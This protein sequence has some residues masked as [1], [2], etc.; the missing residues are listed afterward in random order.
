[1]LIIIPVADK[2]AVHGL[3]GLEVNSTSTLD[4]VLY[5]M[6]I[7]VTSTIRNKQISNRVVELVITD[8]KEDLTLRGVHNSEMV[9]DELV[10]G[11]PC[12]VE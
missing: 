3:K 1:M 5:T 12:A 11:H 2:C 9:S 8:I 10:V 7:F 6:G 4:D